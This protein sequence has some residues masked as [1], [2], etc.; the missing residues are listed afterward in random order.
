MDSK[1]LIFKEK[2]DLIKEFNNLMYLL[3]LDIAVK[4]KTFL[5]QALRTRGNTCLTLSQTLS[6]SE[7][8]YLI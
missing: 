2:F 1:F 6:F 3:R 8:P 4:S 5:V 7:Y